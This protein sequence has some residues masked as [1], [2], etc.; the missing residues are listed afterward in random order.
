MFYANIW[1]H[2]YVKSVRR[3]LIVSTIGMLMHSDDVSVARGC[4][5]FMLGLMTASIAQII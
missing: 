5:L 3:Q 1:F 4:D 2:K